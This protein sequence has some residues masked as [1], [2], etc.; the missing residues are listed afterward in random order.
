MATLLIDTATP[1]VGVAL[2]RGESCVIF[3]TQRI[4]QGAD[5]WLGGAL[6]EVLVSDLDAVAVV[7]G[8]GSFT[9][10]RVGVATA[11]GIAIARKIPVI[12]ISSLCLRA[13]L[14]EPGQQVV[15]LLE[16]RKGYVYSGIFHNHGKGVSV[17]KSESETP[18]ATLAGWLAEHPL[19]LQVGEGC[20]IAGLSDI[21]LLNDPGQTPVAR[22]GRLLSTAP[23]FSATEISLRYL[24]D[25]EYH[26]AGVNPNA[27]P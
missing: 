20:K 11:L 14:A 21:P 9:G 2:Y 10:L 24:R 27:S 7:V 8:P 18:I 25:P 5:A 13:C 4:L 12:P 3:A 19:D 6:T 17:L 15:S 16:A 23:A 1:Q 22:A 26:A